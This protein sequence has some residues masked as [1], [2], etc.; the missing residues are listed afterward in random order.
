MDLLEYPRPIPASGV[1][2]LHSCLVEN[3][4][5]DSLL[6]NLKN[7][8]RNDHIVLILRHRIS[9]ITACKEKKKKSHESI[10]PS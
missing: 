9:L 7:N 1:K 4:W 6:A 5:K 3:A 2:R 8:Q 10:N